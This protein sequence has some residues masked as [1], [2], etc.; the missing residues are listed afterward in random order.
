MAVHDTPI[1]EIDAE[2]GQVAENDRPRGA[3]LD[4]RE[5]VGAQNAA[6]NAGND[7]PEEQAPVDVAVRNV[8]NPRN[9][10]GER[11]GGVHAGRCKGW[12]NADADEDGARNLAEGHPERA[13]HELCREPDEGEDQQCGWVGEDLFEDRFLHLG[14]ERL[15]PTLGLFASMA[16]GPER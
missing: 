7:D 5:D 16:I 11:L 2:H 15:C 12:R 9:A 8:A 4:L 13:V 6:D 14:S 10:G 3:C 1:K